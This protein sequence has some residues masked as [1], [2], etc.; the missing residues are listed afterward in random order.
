M[1]QQ[2]LNKVKNELNVF[3]NKLVVSA[4]AKLFDRCSTRMPRCWRKLAE[5][6]K[7]FQI[8]QHVN[9]FLDLCGG[10]GEFANYTILSNPMCKGFGVTLTNNLV[11]TYKSMVYKHKN[12]TIITGPN[13]SGNVLNKNVAFEI[14]VKCGNVCDLVLADGAVDVRNC[15][16]K[17]ERLNFD[18]IKCE[19]QLILICLRTGGNCV[20]K[21]FDA[22]ETETIE[23]L[24][25]FVN[26]FETWVLYKPPSSRPANSERYLVCLNKLACSQSHNNTDELTTQF[27]KYY[28]AQHRN[29]NKLVKLLKTTPVASI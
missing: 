2:K 16:N 27:N 18:L 19:T 26:H 6:D 5:I 9:V 20:L 21:V 12:F 8:C 4:R 10:P 15:E 13:K 7:K 3:N 17:Q 28:I 25:K 23:L 14:S 1:M 29:L 11:C 24:N 22:F